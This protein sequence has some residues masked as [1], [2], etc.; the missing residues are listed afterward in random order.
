[1]IIR[2]FKKS[3]LKW[4]VTELE[5]FAKEY[6]TKKSLFVDNLT[7]E[8]LVEEIAEN[9]VM[10]IA[11][12]DG[13]ELAGFISGFQYPHPFNPS[14]KMLSENFWWVAKDHRRSRAGAMLLKRFVEF[15]EK[16][17]DQIVMVIED[18][19]PIDE[20]HFLKKGF[21]LKEKSYLLECG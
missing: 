9:H 15:G 11:E 6:A 3:D 19:S 13:G 16:Y 2:P 14:I 10:F 1:M 5:T 4:L 17:F 21:K 8:C 20:K 7:T 18:Q 12:T